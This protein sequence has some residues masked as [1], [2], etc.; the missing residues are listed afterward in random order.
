MLLA[1]AFCADGGH[2]IIYLISQ[3]L[4]SIRQLNWFLFTSQFNAVHIVLV[5]ADNRRLICLESLLVG[6][7][8]RRTVLR[9]LLLNYARV[10]ADRTDHRL[11]RG[12][13]RLRLL[14]LRGLLRLERF[15]LLV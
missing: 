3:F 1:L 15:G 14:L 9:P 11:L 6:I 4:T 10:L 2:L 8:P 5:R 12:L 13:H 7:H